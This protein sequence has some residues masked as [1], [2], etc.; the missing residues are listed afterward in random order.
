MLESLA[1]EQLHG[2]KRSAFKFSNIVNRAD[3]G[4]IERGCGACFPAES[5]DRLRVQRNVIRKEF[6]SNIAAQA[7]VRGFV[8]HAHSSATQFFQNGVVGDGAT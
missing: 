5:L 6:Q 4:V 3:V 1:L 7:R 8:D 2:D